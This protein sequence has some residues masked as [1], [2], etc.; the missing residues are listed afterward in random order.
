MALLRDSA[1]QLSNTTKTNAQWSAITPRW[2][3]NFLPTTLVEA[4]T[5]RVNAVKQCAELLCEH[6]TGDM[7]P[8]T[9][10]D[11][12]DKP[13]EYKL[14]TVQ[15]IIK[16]HTQTIDLY[17]SP[18]DQLG[19]QFRLAAEAIQEE[20]EARYIAS[21]EFGLS[22]QCSEDMR[23]S[24]SH[25]NPDTMDDLLG[26]VWKKPAFF[27]MHPRAM[28]RFG[29]ECTARGVCIGTVEMFGSP[30]FTWRGVP[31][32]P[33]DKIDVGNDGSTEVML[34]RVGE[35]RQG[36]VG[37]AGSAKTGREVAPGITAKFNGTDEQGLQRFLLTRY[38][39]L[40]VLVPDALGILK[41]KV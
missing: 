41:V 13:R 3:L 37:L 6:E 29:Q 20:T 9:F 21:Q 22:S 34:L 8:E 4:G 2:L 10:I 26:K 38:V 17:N 16:A 35:D 30:F 27:L 11:I 39:S 19:E 18:Y 25:P 14:S 40:A 33:S 7:I 32:V 15:T 1:R 36:V 12:E 24:G 5:F 28:V 23:I 31:I